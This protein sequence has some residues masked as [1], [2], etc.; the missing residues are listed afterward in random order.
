M[1]GFIAIIIPAGLGAR[2]LELASL[3]STFPDLNGAHV[4]AV[5]VLMR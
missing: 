4:G 5:A 3:L 1:A 2:E